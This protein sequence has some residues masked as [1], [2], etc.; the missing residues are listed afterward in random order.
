[1]WSKI[2]CGV[3]ALRCLCPNKECHCALELPVCAQALVQNSLFS[4][5]LLFY[6]LYFLGTCFFIYFFEHYIWNISSKQW[7]CWSAFHWVVVNEGRECQGWSDLYLDNLSVSQS[8]PDDD[9]NHSVIVMEISVI[10]L[11]K[12]L[13]LHCSYKWKLLPNAFYVPC[14]CVSL[15]LLP[16]TGLS[17][18]NCSK[19]LCNWGL[20]PRLDKPS[21]SFSSLCCL[22]ALDYSPCFPPDDLLL[23]IMVMKWN[24]WTG[25]I[26]Q[27]ILQ[28]SHT[29]GYKWFLWW[30]QKPGAIVCELW[31]MILVSENQRRWVRIA[32]F[33]FVCQMHLECS[34]GSEHNSQFWSLCPCLA[35]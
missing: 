15:L 19:G 26:I 4:H 23:N 20:F 22:G 16:R 33:L 5:Q 21:L 28:G 29:T 27:L 12:L 1:M 2:L 8:F 18:C 7:I 30:L 10:S 35:K 24:V 14:L 32:S 6:Q 25:S 3:G 34:C 17:L 11:E 31:S 13:V 9:W